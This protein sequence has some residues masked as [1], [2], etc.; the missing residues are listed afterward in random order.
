LRLRDGT[1][2]DLPDDGTILP[3]LDLKPL[4]ERE[5]PLTVFL[6]VP[7]LTL[8]R[9]NLAATP[10][11]TGRYLLDTLQ[12]AD[13]NTGINPQPVQVRRLNLKLLVSSQD[14]A[15]YEILPLAAVEKSG[16]ADAAPQ[17]HLPYIPPI[18]ACDA[19]SPLQNDI[20]QRIYDLVGRK[21]EL[22]AELVASLGISMESTAPGDAL[23]LDQLRVLNEVST[24]LHVI[25]F[26]EGIH[27]LTAFHELC[28]AV[29]QLAI[30]G[31]RQRPP[32][33]PRYDHDDLGS[34]FYQLKREIDT[35]I[36]AVRE[37]EYE[38][39]PFEGIGKRMQASLQQCWLLGQW[40][41]F[42]GVKNLLPVDECINLLT[43]GQLDMKIGSADR[44]ERMFQLGLA[45]LQFVHNAQP[46]RALPSMPG[47]IYFQIIPNS[48][49]W[50]S[51][52]QSLTLAI[53]INEQRIA[54]DI[55]GKR[56]LTV[57]R[58]NGQTTT[59]DFTLY[60]AKVHNAS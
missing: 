3:A 51:V 50:V 43:E 60:V 23:I 41:M 20:L 11:A 27:P 44:V 33:L 48:A 31:I 39:V 34:C 42:V 53:R 59:M 21:I 30:F 56:T 18:L 32:Q 55:Q 19:W 54:G 10:S 37:P 52:Q 5:S 26:T 47:L 25:A 35:L 13:E 22:L 58:A 4:L 45:G 28:R 57:R 7:A 14:D 40:Q 9:A 24:T 6:A 16:G 17:L 1:V 2:L 46:P 49:E 38:H 29:G 8:T 36:E 12:L 15:G